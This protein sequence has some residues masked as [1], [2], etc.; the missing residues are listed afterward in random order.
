MSVVLQ[1]FPR[2]KKQ[3]LTVSPFVKVAFL[4]PVR[5]D[6]VSVSAAVTGVV[7][8]PKAA[9]PTLLAVVLVLVTFSV[10]VSLCAV[11]KSKW[12][13]VATAVTKAPPAGVALQET[14]KLSAG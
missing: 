2:L 13:N 1:L 3:A 4:T 8:H 11:V 9:T 6:V 10:K 12:E 5:T 14:L 7:S